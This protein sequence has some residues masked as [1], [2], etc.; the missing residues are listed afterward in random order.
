MSSQPTI[1]QLAAACGVSPA[2]VSLALRDNTQI[3]A[4]TR[5]KI[6]LAAEK[7]GYRQNPFVSAFMAH[8]R[9]TRAKR[10]L[11]STMA[12]VTDIAQSNFMADSCWKRFLQ[13]ARQRATELG[14]GLDCFF[15]EDLKFSPKRLS[16]VLST[17][18]ITGL[19]LCG[20]FAKDPREYINFS[21]Y[22]AA[23][24]G[25][26]PTQSILT[27][28]ENDHIMMMQRLFSEL[29]ARKYSR[30][31]MALHVAAN[32]RT[33]YHYKLA[34]AHQQMSLPHNERI[35]IFNLSNLPRDEFLVWLETHQP[36]VVISKYE[37]VQEWLQEAG[38]A[39]PEQI[40]YSSLD[41][42]ASDK[43]TSGLYFDDER[44]AAVAVDQLTASIYRNETGIPDI[45]QLVSILGSWVDGT[46]LRQPAFSSMP[47]KASRTA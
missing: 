4:A 34:Y 35:P 18:G 26:N 20:F 24:I 42:A 31:G 11:T 21:G 38:F 2:T 3:S 37:I 36:D 16:Q 12:F 23:I 33:D 32:R 1:R 7:L 13:G 43:V 9:S 8:Q 14:Y 40:G 45:P 41:L 17:R 15:L 25:H 19:L 5:D 30:P 28:A 44:V 39:I 47:E 27:G 46:T 22:S 10:K 6:K 29:E